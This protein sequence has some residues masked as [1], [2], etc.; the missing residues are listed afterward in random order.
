MLRAIAAEFAPAALGV[1][2]KRA[3]PPGR[4]AAC[5]GQEERRH[6]RPG[7]GEQARRPT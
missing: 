4:V 3:R 1:P 2:G 7:A 5:A 6:D